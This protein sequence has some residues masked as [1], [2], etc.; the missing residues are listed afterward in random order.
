MSGPSGAMRSAIVLRTLSTR[1][2]EAVGVIAS[3]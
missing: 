1:P 2:S 3:W